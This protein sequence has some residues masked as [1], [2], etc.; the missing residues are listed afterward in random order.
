MKT[1]VKNENTAGMGCALSGRIGEMDVRQ[2][3]DALRKVLEIALELLKHLNP[4]ISGPAVPKGPDVSI[5][6][7][8]DMVKAAGL[9]R[10]ALL[11]IQLTGDGLYISRAAEDYAEAPEN[12]K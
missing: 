3:L 9:D 1:S 12:E 11:D 10:A 4:K 8:M 7:P 5:Y 6:I 2:T